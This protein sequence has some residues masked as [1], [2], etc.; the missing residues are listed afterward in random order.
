MP[1]CT[2]SWLAIILL[3][4]ISQV[5][6]SHKLYVSSDNNL[7]ECKL[8]FHHECYSLEDYA[9]NHSMIKSNTNLQFLSGNHYL[10]TTLLIEGMSD[11]NLNGCDENVIIKCTGEDSG[12]RFTNS[13]EIKLT[14]LQ[15][16]GCG[17]TYRSR[18]YEDRASM[19]FTRGRNLTIANVTILNA[20]DAGILIINISETTFISHLNV[21]NTISTERQKRGSE[22]A[23]Y[24]NRENSRLVVQDS[25][26]VNNN[27]NFDDGKSNR[28]QVSGLT[29][30]VSNCHACIT[31]TRSTFRNNIGLLS[32]GNIMIDL[33]KIPDITKQNVTLSNLH[34]EGG[35]AQKGGGLYIFVT[36]NENLSYTANESQ[37]SSQ[38]V[39]ENV[40]FSGNKA[41][42]LGAA[43]FTQLQASPQ[44]IKV[45]H[46]ISIANCT[47]VNN[48]LRDGDKG[49]I[50]IHNNYFDI[51]SYLTQFTP[52]YKIVLNNCT[53]KQHYIRN[54]TDNIGGNS[55]LFINS[56]NYFEVG[57]VIITNNSVNAITAVKSNLLLKGHIT[58]S[59]N[60][61]SSGGGLLLCQ[62]ATIYLTPYTTMDISYNRVIHNGGGIYVEPRCL[63]EQPKCFFQVDNDVKQN[64]TLLST[65][66]VHIHSNTAGY[67]G[68]DLYGGDVDYCYMIDS[69]D[70]NQA[71]NTSL[72]VY[73]EVFNVSN[74]TVAS[75]PRRI[76]FCKNK[77]MHCE[78]NNTNVSSYPGER[79]TV[80]AVL[81]GQ[82]NGPVPG[83]V[84]T[85][86]QDGIQFKYDVQ[87]ITNE[88]SP[89]NYTIKSSS[90]VVHLEIGA[91][92][93]GDQSGYERLKQYERKDL[94][95]FLKS[96]PIGF[97][98]DTD[99]D[100]S[101]TCDS[102]VLNFDDLECH[103]KKGVFIK[104]KQN[105]NTWIG[106]EHTNSTTGMPRAIKYNANCPFDY[107][108]K[109]ELKLHLNKSA[110][111]VCA[112]NRLG[113]MCGAC[114]ESYSTLLGSTKCEKCS[115]KHL[116]L[117]LCFALAGLLLVVALTL[118]NLTISEGSLSGLI[119]YANVIECNSSFVIPHSNHYSFPTPVFRVFIAWI[120]LDIGMA[121]CFFNGMDEYAEAW[122]QFAFP[123]YIWSI[124]IVIILLS[125]K[126]QLV[127]R[128]ASRSAVK[129]L[130]TLVLLSY[131]T[132]TH[133]IISTF[134]FSIVHTLAE[135]NTTVTET[136]WLLDG[137]I[138]FFE[139]KHTLLF[140]TALLLGLIT[141][142]FTLVLL[143]IRPLQRFSHIKLFRWVET[144]KPFLDAFTG[145]YTSSGR[146][147]PGL[148]LLARI[149]LS[150]S[151]GL[152]TLSAHQVVH[153]A[154]SLVIIILL[155]T[156]AL[157]RPGL[158]TIQAL[159]AL[160][161]FFLLNLSVLFLGSMYYD[162]HGSK[163]KAVFDTTVGSAFLA[164]I[165][166][167][168]Y[169]LL[170]KTRQYQ[171]SRIAMLWLKAKLDDVRTLIWRE[172]RACTMREFPPYRAFTEE[173]EPLL[174]DHEE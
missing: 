139:L 32:G 117:L 45:H 11:V 3:L 156:A 136:R 40:R 69:P 147:W 92:H 21:S 104:R 61:G 138:A 174:S 148:L 90:H 99:T 80:E 105:G 108:R 154:T 157:V 48:S 36:K 37:F 16:I 132:L 140:A 107:C 123:L 41:D 62:G 173:R 98:L 162:G 129:V 126:F 33:V 166:I 103:V 109:E 111:K 52:Q 151:G 158:Y 113:I 101:S 172:N 12:F 77:A 169:H 142:P 6:A 57:N 68:N 44:M 76:C 89:L 70:K 54:S 63:I 43:L 159:D 19:V 131:A 128:I 100:D 161:Y 115:N 152:N 14:N 2:V 71:P 106:F 116:I 4:F 122:L 97:R 134:S 137:N 5:S 23:Y 163:Q 95:V 59:H 91:Q 118:L 86:V 88:C 13:S 93:T 155:S 120:N 133:A 72:E 29:V 15:F 30:R 160:E 51:D 34:I 53:F 28:T 83:V 168:I 110:T 64:S 27:Y 74:H 153:S 55:V 17:T 79:F 38:T 50:A 58:L 47:F 10:N 171:F 26:F 165:V 8:K 31:I 87:N 24:D 143:F 170:L 56:H 146:F 114:K 25:A 149:C 167:V 130:A 150:I 1:S 135:D 49:G 7:D 119:F 121:T 127:A 141:L 82:L 144:L 75:P 67:G 145:P 96:C 112:N 73:R 124:A 20:L 18:K 81:V 60:N 35:N 65:V 66:K 78:K 22:I 42:Y 39:I 164:F 94:K 9:T 85:W 102:C 84:R 46:T 125:S